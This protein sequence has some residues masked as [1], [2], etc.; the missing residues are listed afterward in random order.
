MTAEILDLPTWLFGIV[1][2]GSFIAV[3]VVLT[4]ALRPFVRRHYADAHN[5]VLDICFSAVGTMFAIVAGLLVFGVYSTFEDAQQASSNEASNLIL[6]H[7]QAN[8]FPQPYRDQAQQAI[9]S[10]TRSVID[11]D[12][13]ALANSE[14]SV[15]TGAALDHMYSVWAPMQPDEQWS[16][17]YQASVDQLNEVLRLR[18]ERI[19]D[20]RAALAPI[21]W[22]LL[23]VGAFLTVLHL[24]LLR[25][26][27]LTMHLIAVGVTAAMLALVLLLLIEVNQPFRGDTSL[28]PVSYERALRSMTGPPQ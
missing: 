22:V 27:N 13:P 11:D 16:D 25:M 1:F 24:V 9:V 19:D 17:Q 15:K 2:I 5:S 21:Y 14:G 12:W 8:A 10:Y 26:E 18:D 23:F 3:S 20:S 4:V 6:M 7:K 28:L